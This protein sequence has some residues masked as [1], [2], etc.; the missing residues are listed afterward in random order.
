MVASGVAV[1][2]LLVTLSLH[3][4]IFKAIGLRRGH[5]KALED[6][7][8]TEIATKDCF[9]G[10]KRR[11]LEAEVSQFRRSLGDAEAWARLSAEFDKD[12]SR[13]IGN[14]DDGG[15]YI[16][17]NYTLTK[18]SPKPAEWPSILRAVKRTE[19]IQG[20]SIAEFKMKVSDGPQPHPADFVSIE[21]EVRSR[22]TSVPTASQ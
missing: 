9:S 12:W 17:Q 8:L 13:K 11:A 7:V 18:D 19:S 15:E 21:V 2:A 4:K 20:V 16:I 14:K 6:A 1:L 10:E 3:M 22:K 5:D